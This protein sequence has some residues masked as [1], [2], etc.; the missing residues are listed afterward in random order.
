MK[1]SSAAAKKHFCIEFFSLLASCS[2]RLPSYFIKFQTLCVFLC[3]MQL[4]KQ[5][6][7]KG[8]KSWVEKWVKRMKNMQIWFF[9]SL[10]LFF[11]FIHCQRVQQQQFHRMNESKKQWEWK[12]LTSL[13]FS[14][15][16]KKERKFSPLRTQQRFW[17]SF[18]T[19][20]S[21]LRAS[22][23]LCVSL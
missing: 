9:F 5:R 12:L 7:W 22:E 17:F 6:G 10:L 13:F 19:T 20:S 16:Q 2:K 14:P 15:L 23:S 4:E 11:S 8:M 21:S 1:T 18:F 3:E